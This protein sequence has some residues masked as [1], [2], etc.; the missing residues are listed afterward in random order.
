MKHNIFDIKQLSN[1]YEI[2]K[3]VDYKC[4]YFDVLKVNIMRDDNEFIV[5]LLY[6]EKTESIK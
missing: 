2:K 6:S 5:F 1:V 3:W 4:K